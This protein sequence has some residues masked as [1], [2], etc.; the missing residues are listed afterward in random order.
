MDVLGCGSV[1][2]LSCDPACLSPL[3]DWHTVGLHRGAGCSSVP[4]LHYT[5]FNNTLNWKYSIILYHHPPICICIY[6]GNY[7]KQSSQW[8]FIYISNFDLYVI[9]CFNYASVVLICRSALSF[10]EWLKQVLRALLAWNSPPGGAIS[11]QPAFP[12]STMVAH[13]T[14]LNLQSIQ[15]FCTRNKESDTFCTWTCTYVIWTLKQ[16]VHDYK[17]G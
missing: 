13:Y 6:L 4:V 7:R 2:L 3:T 8:R 11:L 16:K 17:W 14:Q 9:F 5:L 1:W 12:F 15:C 10:W